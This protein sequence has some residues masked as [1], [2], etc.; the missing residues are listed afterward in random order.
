LWKFIT[1]RPGDRTDVAALGDT[2]RGL[3]HTPPPTRFALPR[4]EILGRILPRVEN[5]P[6]PADDK[7]FLLDRLA[8]LK[9]RLGELHFPLDPAPTHGDAHVKNLMIH[10]GEPVLID[11][12]RFAWGQPEWD[13]AMTATEYVTAGWWTDE[14][15]G[16]FVDAYGYDVTAWTDG[17]DVL[18]A[19]HEL[20]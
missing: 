7:R 4:E 10:E 17:F 1:G 2:L 14:E 9:I 5:S 15:Y 18:R 11:F 16:R 6:I 19:V 12:E 3:H 8:E 13:L 20:E